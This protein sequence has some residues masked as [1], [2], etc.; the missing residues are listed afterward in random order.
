MVINSYKVVKV[1]KA[2]DKTS[3]FSL[4]DEP[5]I[6][7]YTLKIED[8]GQSYSDKTKTMK[9]SRFIGSP[10]F[11]EGDLIDEFGGDTIRKVAAITNVEIADAT[12]YTGMPT[13]SYLITTNIFK[14]PF[15]ILDTS[16]E[17]NAPYVGQTIHTEIYTGNTDT[18]IM[19]DEYPPAMFD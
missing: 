4:S 13:P 6:T 14:K 18:E 8:T 19:V 11:K 17:G 10:A 16:T 2:I 12:D 3:T 9:L 5:D 7:T 1:L 15:I